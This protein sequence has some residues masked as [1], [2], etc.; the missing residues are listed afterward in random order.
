[1]LRKAALVHWVTSAVT[2][3]E[4]KAPAA[5]HVVH[6]IRDALADEVGQ[7]LVQVFI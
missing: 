2:S 7:F 4:P 3:K 1:L 5:L 6:A